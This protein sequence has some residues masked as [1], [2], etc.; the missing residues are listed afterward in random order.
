L[1]FTYPKASIKDAQAA[2][3]AF[4]PEI[5]QLFFAVNFCPP[6]SGSATLTKRVVLGINNEAVKIL[7]KA[8]TKGI[9]AAKGLLAP[10][11]RNLG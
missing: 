7:W 6:G 11:S 1:Q 10:S 3:E 5:S 4:R 9:I 2:G 8:Q